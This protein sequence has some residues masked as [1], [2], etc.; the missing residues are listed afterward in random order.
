MNERG[1][2]GGQ[3]I[4]VGFF[5]RNHPPATLRPCV[6]TCCRPGELIVLRRNTVC[7]LKVSDSTVKQAVPR[8]RSRAAP[9]PHS[10]MHLFGVMYGTLL[11]RS[12]TKWAAN[13]RGANFGQTTGGGFLIPLLH[14]TGGCE[15]DLR[16]HLVSNL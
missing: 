7:V 3:P 12:A 2:I 1:K 11:G 8:R 15:G 5:D 9:H 6:S 16:L 4:S 13:T 10:Y 14:V